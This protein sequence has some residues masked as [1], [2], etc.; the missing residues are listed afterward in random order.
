MQVTDGLMKTIP[1]ANL[2]AP[3][4]NASNNTRSYLAWTV[5]SQALHQLLFFLCFEKSVIKTN[6]SRPF[7]S[8]PHPCYLSF[9]QL[10]QESPVSAITAGSPEHFLYALK[11]NINP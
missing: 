10:N 3:I 1:G 11:E 5:R 8:T 2:K 9:W 6:K 7:D 4:T